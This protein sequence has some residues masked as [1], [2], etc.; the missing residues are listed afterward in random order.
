MIGPYETNSIL[1]GDALA[2]CDMIPDESIDAIVCD[3]VYDEIEQYAWLA[4]LA[5]RVLKAGGSV[6]AQTG[7][8]HRFRAECAL[9]FTGEPLGLVHRPLLTEVFSGGF[10]QLWMHKALRAGQHYLWMTKTLGSETADHN[11][12]L[13][14]Y[15]WLRTCF[16]GQKDRR[17]HKTWGDGAA[18]TAY[19]IERLVPDGGIVLDPFTGGGTVPAVCKMLSRRWLAFEINAEQY[20]RAVARLSDTSD[21]MFEAVDYADKKQ[22]N[23]MGDQS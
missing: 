15:H 23:F 14:P 2:L 12:D 7:S 20:D 13:L 8:I 6:V 4:R 3:P 9:V 21:P 22:L 17:F 5:A 18:A 16:W 10:G 1:H 19:L 11:D